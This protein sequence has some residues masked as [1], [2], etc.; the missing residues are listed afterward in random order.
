MGTDTASRQCCNVAAHVVV[1]AVL[2]I[3]GSQPE[4][5]FHLT[6][7]HIGLREWAVGPARSCPALRRF[8][9]WS[10]NLFRD[11]IPALMVGPAPSTLPPASFHLPCMRCKDE[12]VAQ[13]LH[14]FWHPQR[15][16]NLLGE[17]YR[18]SRCVCL[19]VQSSQ[20]GI[21]ATRASSL[22]PSKEASAGP[23]SESWHCSAVHNRQSSEDLATPSF[24]RALALQPI[25]ISWLT[26]I[27]LDL[28]ITNGVRGA[29][30]PF[31]ES[32]T[33]NLL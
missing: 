7:S 25:T 22:W 24:T 9:L 12:G 18:Q 19:L 3:S 32:C 1:P 23:V 10:P 5:I 26:A 2:Q 21:S 31:M 13:L 17:D 28:H 11:I 30:I 33:E 15:L 27:T 16:N 14:A 6:I 20:T 29:H 4:N 8:S